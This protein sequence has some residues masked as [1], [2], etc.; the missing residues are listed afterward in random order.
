T[1]A[2]VQVLRSMYQQA[3][4]QASIVGLCVGTRPDCVPQAVVDL[5]CV[6]NIREMDTDKIQHEPKLPMKKSFAAMKGN[7]PWILMVLANLI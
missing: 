7:W 2:E 6:K 3:V 1:F 4:S 5:L